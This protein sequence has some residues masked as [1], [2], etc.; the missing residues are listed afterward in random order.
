MF[1]A[2]RL[3]MAWVLKMGEQVATADSISETHR[4]RR[5]IT[6]AARPKPIVRSAHSR[7]TLYPHHSGGAHSLKNDP[8]A[9]F[10]PAPVPTLCDHRVLTG[11]TASQSD[12]CSPLA[13]YGYPPIARSRFDRLF[14]EIAPALSGL[15]PT[16]TADLG[17]VVRYDF[18]AI[19]KLKYRGPIHAGQTA[20]L[21]FRLSNDDQRVRD[22]NGQGPTLR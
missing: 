6:C 22:H 20:T 2:L 13:R 12:R 18:L 11:R 3:Q 7:R 1:G 5:R 15:L 17:C 9:R 14:L 21:Q 4:Q 8:Q 10:R 19:A 16:A